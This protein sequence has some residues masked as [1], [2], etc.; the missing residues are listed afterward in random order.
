MNHKWTWLVM[1]SAL[2]LFATACGDDG[3]DDGMTGDDDDDDMV[4]VDGGVRD[5]GPVECWGT[6]C[7]GDG[8]T[9][10][11]GTPAA[12]RFCFE[13]G[14][15]VVWGGS[16]RPLL[17]SDDLS[18][19][20]E[21]YETTNFAG[22]Y[23]SLVDTSQP[24]CQ[25]NADCSF[26]GCSG[27]C[28]G[29]GGGLTGC[30][31]A[32][33]PGRSDNG[34]CRDGYTCDLSAGACLP[35]C[36]SDDECRVQLEDTNNDGVLEAFEFGTNPT[37][38][39]WVYDVESEAVCNPE[40]FRCDNPGTEGVSAGDPCDR[41][42]EC[43]EDG[44]CL[45]QESGFIG[46]G[47]CVKESCDGV[48]RGCGDG[49]ICQAKG[50]GGTP[51]CLAAC[52]FAAEF[53]G[54]TEENPVPEAVFASSADC[55]EGYKCEWIGTTD[56]VTGRART[57]G[58]CLPG[59]FT[60][61]REPNVGGT[62]TSNDDCWSPLGNG[63]CNIFN[64]TDGAGNT[65]E[66]RGECILTDCSPGA[67][68]LEPPGVPSEDVYCGET[69]QCFLVDNTPPIG[70]R[71]IKTCDDASV[72]ADGFACNPTLVTGTNPP[73]LCWIDCVDRETGQPDSSMCRVGEE[74]SGGGICVP[75][76]T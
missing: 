34:P 61:V 8:L 43:M 71:C 22:G 42:S 73:S 15:T 45:V 28:L 16:E 1:L 24:V 38:D 29:V 58:A 13:E 63:I 14:D 65:I 10:C 60:D 62:C 17:N 33:D 2:A 27:V 57:E 25:T 66:T 70:T 67:G 19:R 56:P 54:A 7:A 4:M 40:T 5:G 47:Y 64:I 3:G 52:D 11:P 76:G 36:T 44:T 72:C 50:F 55:R 41:S 26:T 74:C 59:N 68:G 53:D 23:C 30:F 46:G 51:A 31:L 49:E 69:A 35:G 39:R 75:E 32:C 21:T 20:D 37:G 9:E 6:P 12:A 48:G 18:T